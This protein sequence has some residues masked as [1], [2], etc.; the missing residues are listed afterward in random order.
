M[1]TEE[2][3]AA[4]L[5]AWNE[6]D[7]SARRGLLERCW[8]AAGTYTDPMSHVDGRD[9]LAAHIAQFQQ[10][11]PGARIART[12]GIDEHHGRVRFAWSLRP[13]DGAPPIDGIDIGE[14]DVDGRLR[15]IIGFFGP[16]PAL[17]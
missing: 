15:A 4:Y 10:Q 9:A 13:P 17:P 1:S 8:A 2:T 11:M 14:L 12:S 7:A 6:P 16:P 3:V 5:A